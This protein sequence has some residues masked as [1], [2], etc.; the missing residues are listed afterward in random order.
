MDPRKP[1]DGLASGAMVLLGIIWSLQQIAIKA[2]AAEISPIMMIGL[3]SGIA[4]LLVAALMAIRGEKLWGYRLSPLAGLTIGALFSVEYLMLGEALRL[5]SAG[6]AV[7][8]LY[9][10]PIFAAVGLHWKLPL[11]R[12][13]PLQWAGVFIAFGG[14]AYAFFAKGNASGDDQMA[15]L[16]DALA[17]ASGV[18]WGATTVVIRT[19]GLSQLP[20]SVTLLYQLV[21]AALVLVPSAVLLGQ[22]GLHPS[23]IGWSNLAFQAVVVSFLSFLVWFWLLRH[24]LASRLGVFSFLTP[25]FGILLGAALLGETIEPTFLLGAAFVVAGVVLVSSARL[26]EGAFG[27]VFAKS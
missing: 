17:L 1:L 3:R 20:A 10:A 26:I 2:T 7:V 23:W 12:L 22:G 15:L 27:R 19:T 24:Y 9:T 6:H 14:I 21:I 8:F 25:V 13:S 18:A 5:T 11:E 4:A 16:G